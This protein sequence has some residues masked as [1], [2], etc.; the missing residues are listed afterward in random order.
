MAVFMMQVS[1]SSRTGSWGLA[2][3]LTHMC[4]SH[5][6]HHQRVSFS[7]HTSHFQSL[8]PKH[9][10]SV[11]EPSGVCG[12]CTLAILAKTET[13]FCIKLN[14]MM[15]PKCQISRL[16]PHQ[17]M[18][19]NAHA[20]Q[21][22]PPSAPQGQGSSRLRGRC[23]ILYLLKGLVSM[24]IRH[25]MQVHRLLYF[26]LSRLDAQISLCSQLIEGLSHGKH[27]ILN[28]FYR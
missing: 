22:C 3:T 24:G 13:E 5:H 14:H 19:V 12:E 15:V 4:W 25:L 18:G 8:F 26:A 23:F 1:R 28:E 10:F 9:S 27:Q 7:T 6:Q 11:R 20:D 2:Q 16:Q 21:L 17:Q